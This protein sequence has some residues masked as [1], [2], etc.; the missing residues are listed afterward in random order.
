MAVLIKDKETDRLIR[1]LAKRSGQSITESV[2]M[3]VWE[4]LQKIP[5]DENEIAARKRKL[6]ELRAYFDSL[7]KANEHLT[8]DEIIGYNEHGHFD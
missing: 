4:R 7:P 2:K 3:A 8:I 1:E 5:L 6:A